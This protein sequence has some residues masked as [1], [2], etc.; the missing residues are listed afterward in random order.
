MYTQAGSTKPTLMVEASTGS[1]TI[2]GGPT[3][4]GAHTG[5][6][7]RCRLA[8]VGPGTKVV[9]PDDDG[10]ESVFAH[11]GAPSDAIEVNRHMV[12]VGW[13]KY[14]DG[15]VKPWPYAQIRAA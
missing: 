10:G 4:S 3:G 5:A 8:A 11:R 15:T 9:V 14:P 1:E 6:M 2:A 7:G 12:D 13:V